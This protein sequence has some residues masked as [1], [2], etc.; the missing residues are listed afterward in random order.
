ML[1]FIAW[2]SVAAPA[3]T[4]AAPV[5]PVVRSAESYEALLAEYEAAVKAWKTKLGEAGDREQRKALR[6]QRPTESFAPRFTALAE[7]G[8]GRA[9]L[10]LLDNLRYLGLSV[11]EREP[12]RRAWYEQLFA[13]HVEAAWF[14]DALSQLWTDRKRFDEGDTLSSWLQQRPRQEPGQRSRRTSALLPR[15]RRRALGRLDGAEARLRGARLARRRP[16]GH[17]V[18]GPGAP[19]PVP[20]ARPRGGGDG[21]RLRRKTVDGETFR[22]SDYRGKVVLLDFWGFW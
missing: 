1:T 5:V 17:E 9:I 22:L 3:P 6:K 4:H 19:R 15:L 20:D 18:R 7:S 14:G 2:L 13:Q 21:D 11:R 12:Q 8:E 10:W 16:A